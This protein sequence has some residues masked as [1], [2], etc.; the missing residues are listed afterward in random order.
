MKYFAAASLTESG[1]LLSDTDVRVA[2]HS[3]FP[4]MYVLTTADAGLRL[5]QSTVN[6][7][8]CNGG[9]N[10]YQRALVTAVFLPGNIS[11]RDHSL[12]DR[13]R[14]LVVINPRSFSNEELR[15]QYPAI[16]KAYSCLLLEYLNRNNAS[17]MLYG[18][19]TAAE[20]AGALRLKLMGSL[21]WIMQDFYQVTNVDALLSVS[22]IAYLMHSGGVSR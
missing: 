20:E 15:H 5:L 7:V 19:S 14:A 8:K 6:W 1:L 12:H 4:M 3:Y 21:I 11:T 17:L 9:A 16:C 2:I 18:Q 10:H 13:V 22:D